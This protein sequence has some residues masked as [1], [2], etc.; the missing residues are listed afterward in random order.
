MK[1][2][3][4]CLKPPLFQGYIAGEPFGLASNLSEPVFPTSRWRSKGPQFSTRFK[5]L[6][7]RAFLEE[8]PSAAMRTPAPRT[9]SKRPP[10]CDP[11]Y[12]GEKSENE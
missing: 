1:M 12:N 6:T 2:F 10:Q 7:P 3:N 4:R 11:S 9:R 5:G 8:S